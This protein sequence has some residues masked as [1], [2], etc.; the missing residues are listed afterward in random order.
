MFRLSGTEA[1]ARTPSPSKGKGWGA[2]SS[3]RSAIS[4]ILSDGLRASAANLLGDLASL[5][6]GKQGISPIPE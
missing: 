5:A 6:A 3:L 2:A 4:A 1:M